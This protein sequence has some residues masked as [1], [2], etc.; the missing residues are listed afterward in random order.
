M[1]R[2]KQRKIYLYL[3]IVL[4]LT[5]GFA[6]LST[7]LFINGTASIKSNTWNIHWDESSIDVAQGSVSATT[8]EV[9]TTTSTDDTLSFEVQLD[10]PGDF[11]E[12]EIDAVNDGSIDGALDT[13]VTKIYDSNDQE[14][15]GNNI[16]SY[17]LYSVT[18]DDDTTPSDGDVLAHGQ[19]QTY[20]IRVEFDEDWTEEIAS[21]E[22]YQI[23]VTIP[24]VQYQSTPA[25]DEGPVTITANKT[26]AQKNEEVKVTVTA[27]DVA[28]WNLHLSG[29][30]VSDEFVGANLD[31]DGENTTVSRE[32]T[33][34]TS[35]AGEK[36]ITLTGDVTDEDN[37][38]TIINKSITITVTE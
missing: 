14:L 5:I 32:F 26:T 3:L 6:L 23:K 7:T 25:V 20:K 19:S 15:T 33:L 16:P 10:L 18:Y 29:A 22:V 24:Y 31:G 11:Y 8:P 2:K 28:A 27:T 1:K 38:K 36:V 34:D 35:T 30:I 12:F 21:D 13:M 37:H 9:T 4:G 17:L